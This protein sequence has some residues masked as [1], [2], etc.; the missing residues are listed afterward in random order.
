MHA[1]NYDTLQK[2]KV[3]GLQIGADNDI[4]ALIITGRNKPLA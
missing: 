4:K 1:L 2:I 3:A